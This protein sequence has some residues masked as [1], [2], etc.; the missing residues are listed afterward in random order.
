M[1]LISTWKTETESIELAQIHSKLLKVYTCINVK[2][3]KSLM[4]SKLSSQVMDFKN[5]HLFLDKKKT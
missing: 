3:A 4:K 2:Q 1:R 5:L